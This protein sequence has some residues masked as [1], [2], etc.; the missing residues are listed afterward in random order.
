MYLLSKDTRFIK[1]END[2]QYTCRIL[3]LSKFN[4][5]AGII[6]GSKTEDISLKADDGKV[7]AHAELT[8]TMR[9]ADLDISSL[10]G[11]SI[12][13]VTKRY[14]VLVSKFRRSL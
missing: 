7:I 1:V 13:S 5:D 8:M 12:R 10:S 11:L 3:R 2:K 14:V 9:R 6:S 4:I